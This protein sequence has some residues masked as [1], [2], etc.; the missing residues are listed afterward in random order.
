MSGQETASTRFS[1][2]EGLGAPISAGGMVHLPYLLTNTDSHEGNFDLKA[3]ASSSRPH[4]F[5][6]T[7]RNGLPDGDAPIAR[8]GIL[9]P[10]EAF[11]FVVSV[12]RSDGSP[13]RAQ[14]ATVTASAVRESEAFFGFTPLREAR[15]SY[16][17]R[18]GEDS[19]FSNTPTQQFP[20]NYNNFG[21]DYSG[22]HNGQVILESELR[23][24]RFFLVNVRPL[25]AYREADGDSVRLLEG[26]ASL[27][28][29]PLEL[30][31]GRQSLWWGQ[32]RNGSLVLTSNARPLDM[33]RLT[34]P[35]PAHLPWIFKYL[36]PFRFDLFV[37]RLEED[38]VVPEP[39]FSGLR[40][41]FKPA[42]WFE[43]GASRTALFGGEGRPDVKFDD[44]L[45]IIGGENVG[46]SSESNQIAA[47]DARLKFPY[48]G[49]AEIYGEFGGEDE[50][51]AL[52]FIPFISQVAY[53]GGIYLPHI[54]PSGRI[55]LRLE[56]TDTTEQRNG[57]P[58]WYRHSIYQSGY[59]YEGN[60]L[61]HHIGGDAKDLY[62]E[63]RAFLPA[64]LTLTLAL[65]L[66]ERGDSLP[67]QEEHT[68]PSV[69]LEWQAS[70]GMRL[71]GRYARDR[72][73]NFAFVE[74]DDKTMHFAEAG[75]A[76]SW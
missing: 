21:I 41:N 74:G 49:G 61:G 45:T 47:L 10:G 76:F 11:H 42:P 71:H 22:N 33:V 6:D 12:P 67:V 28:M 63:L 70:P 13:S 30:S 3:S 64:D 72:V 56:Y 20:P 52:G 40:F 23:L 36:G 7:D 48:L 8:T 65:D 62:A 18:Q 38:R 69:K 1:L 44:F 50:A 75:V 34:N 53:L 26:K 17:Y 43:F 16:V 66:Q 19:L 32:G 24:G 46:G 2:T 58:V 5:A 54:E 59:T 35:S 9:A 4:V 37:S 39:Y 57:N 55:D 68:I 25:L 14:T 31:A 27:G 15:F 60:I 51:D 29:G 73:E